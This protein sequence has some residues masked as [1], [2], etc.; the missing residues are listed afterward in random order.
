[1][2]SAKLDAASKAVSLLQGNVADLVHAE[3]LIKLAEVEAMQAQAAASS[4]LARV[5]EHKRFA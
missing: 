4:A 1:M 2:S 3:L 5:V